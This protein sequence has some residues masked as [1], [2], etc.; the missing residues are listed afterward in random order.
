MVLAG[1]V[2]HFGQIVLRVGLPLGILS[3]CIH[4]LAPHLT[5]SVWA[6][7]PEQLARIHWTA[8]ASAFVLTAISLWTVGRY[9]GVAHQHFATRIPRHQARAAGTI[10]I[11]LAQTLGAGVFTGAF[12]RWRMLPDVTSKMSL[13]LSVFVSLSFMVC[14][15]IVTALSCLLF[16][17]PSWTYIPSLLTLSATPI[18]LIAMFRWPTIHLKGYQFRFPNLRSSAAIL[19]WT[20]IDTTAVAGAMY[21]LLPSG[22]DIAFTVFLPLFLLALGTALLS[23][24]PGGVGP[25]EL[26]ML[27]LLPQLPAGEILGSIIAFRIVYYALPA[28]GAALSLLRP[29]KRDCPRKIPENLAPNSAGQVDVQ[30]IVQNGGRLLATANGSCAIWPTSQTLTSLCNPLSGDMLA[31]LDAINAEAEV[32]GKHP[33]FY[34][35]NGKNAAV[36]SAKKWSVIHMSDDAVVFPQTFT[37][38]QPNLRNLRRKLGA[39]QKS[40]MVI[41]IDK[42]CPWSDMQRIDHEWQNAHGKARGGTMGRFEIGYLSNHFIARGRT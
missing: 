10:A 35:C 8:W 37:L 26:M 6:G 30:V 22:A 17:A 15:M 13:K 40:G 20:L 3:I 38:E 31:A 32:L 4:Q 28:C 12:A 23:N 39:A 5:Q 19:F 29:F 2:K 41:K 11:A 7:F 18:T 14:W 21:V 25:F 24:T 9:D 27:G 42:A 33:F 16:P 36:L 1:K 34:K